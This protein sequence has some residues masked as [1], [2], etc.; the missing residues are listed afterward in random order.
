MFGVVC[1]SLRKGLDLIGQYKYRKDL[2]AGLWKE[3]QSC[4]RRDRVCL[5]WRHCDKSKRICFFVKVCVCVV[6]III[7]NKR[8]NQ[9]GISLA[10]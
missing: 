4:K 2:F 10:M 6:K 9:I 7:R 5:S 3:S 8:I 1:V